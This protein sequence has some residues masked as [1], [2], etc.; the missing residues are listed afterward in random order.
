M[1]KRVVWN[2]RIRFPSSENKPQRKY[3]LVHI[4]FSISYRSWGGSGVSNVV[5]DSTSTGD[6]GFL[7]SPLIHTTPCLQLVWFHWCIMKRRGWPFVL[8]YVY[9]L[10]SVSSSTKKKKKNFSLNNSISNVICQ[11]KNIENS[12]LRRKLEFLDQFIR[13]LLKKKQ[14]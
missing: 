14:K 9:M 13:F 2:I 12:S 6:I 11:M 1:I 10:R 4:D 5:E 8:Y 7:H 3:T